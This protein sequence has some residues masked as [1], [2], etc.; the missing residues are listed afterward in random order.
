MV[1]LQVTKGL[2]FRPKVRK[3]PGPERPSIPTT[4]PLKRFAA[5]EPDELHHADDAFCIR[6]PMGSKV[7]SATPNSPGDAD[8]CSS[9]LQL[10][11]DSLAFPLDCCFKHLLQQCKLNCLNPEPWQEFSAVSRLRKHLRLPRPQ[12]VVLDS[13]DRP[14]QVHV[15]VTSKGR[16]LSVPHGACSCQRD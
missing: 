5:G 1:I 13:M 14:Y 8:R 11:P 15:P 9:Q 10:Q 4:G 12:L 3:N 7:N 16:R 2:V 6:S